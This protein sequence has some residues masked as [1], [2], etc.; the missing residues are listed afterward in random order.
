MFAY[1]QGT[2]QYAYKDC[3]V[4]ENQGIGYK[5]LTAGSTLSQLPL[6]GEKVKIHTHLHVREDAFLLYGFI[7][8][9]E[10]K[11]FE[12]LITVSGIGPKAALGIL[13]SISLS[14]FSLQVVSGDAKGLTKVP[15]IGP[16]TA[17]R[18]ILDLKDKLHSQQQ[19]IELPTA[20][21][22]QNPDVSEAVSALMVLGYNAEEA[23]KAVEAIYLPSIP[24]EQVIKK[25]LKV[26]SR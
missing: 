26:L 8:E 14:Q 5:I 18:I 7:T 23:S 12:L 11:L 24:V 15:G 1:I 6:I 17:Q 19:E 10:L 20:F 4:I 22:Q 16:K 3:L 2:L 13:S 25:A 21:E 9:E